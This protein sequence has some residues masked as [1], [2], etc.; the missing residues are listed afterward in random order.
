MNSIV[1][2]VVA[3]AGTLL[4][5]TITYVL[6]A[7]GARQAREFALGQQIWQERLAAYSAFVG[8]MTDFRRSQNDRWHREQ[9][10]PG[11]PAFVSARDESYQLRAR[12]TA[13][14]FRVQ[15]VSASPALGGLA[16]RALAAAAEIP[17]AA[18]EEDR[19]S[20]GEKARLALQDFLAEASGDVREPSKRTRV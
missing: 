17:M 3:I 12:A 1:A 18:D 14:M 13:E 19:A 15:L 5:A 4:G 10:D 6:Q 9:E 8:A 20:R 7:R 2:G 16:E 11:S